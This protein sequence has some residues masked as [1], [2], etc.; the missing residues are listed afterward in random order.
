MDTSDNTRTLLSQS[1]G[2]TARAGALLAPEL[3]IG[4]SVLLDGSLGAGK[5]VFAKGLAIALGVAGEGVRSP[6]F[7]LVNIYPGPFPVY[8]I[9]LYR[10]EKPEE[11]SELGLEEMIGTDGVAIVEWPDRLGPYMPK[12]AIWVRIKDRGGDRREITIEDRR[13][14]KL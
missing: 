9:D 4:D 10:I 11:L 3:V 1:A 8:H 7:T 13:S 5:T 2:D 12:G 14:R 6:T